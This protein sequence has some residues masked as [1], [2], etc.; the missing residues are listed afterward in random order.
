VNTDEIPSSILHKLE[1]A[2]KRV[3]AP[4]NST[5]KQFESGKNSNSAAE[6]GA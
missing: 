2:D 1:G 4:D 5:E 3:L 6:E